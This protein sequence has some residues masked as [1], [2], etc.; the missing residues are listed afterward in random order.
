MYSAL[1]VLLFTLFRTV[2]ATAIYSCQGSSADE[3]SSNEGNDLAIVDQ[4]EADWWKAERDG[5]VYVVPVVY[6]EITEG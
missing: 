4:L 6:V 1:F 3:L 2:K 5:F